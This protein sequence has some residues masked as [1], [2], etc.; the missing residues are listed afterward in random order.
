[1]RKRLFIQVSL[2]IICALWSTSGLA[3]AQTSNA[4][5][6]GTV[7]DPS[8]S[9][10]A[11]ATVKAQ[12]EATGLQRTAVTESSGHYV[13]NFLPVG[14]YVVTAE[15]RGF[16]TARL[17][18]VTLEIGQTRSLDIALEVG[19]VEQTVEI[20]E[21][22]PP[23]D[24]NSATVGTV[25]QSS[26][27]KELPLNGRNWAGLMLLAPGAINTGEGNHLSTRF[28]GRSR[29][30][31]NWTFDGVDST[32]VKDPRQEANLRLVI[33][34]DSIS[35]FRVSSTLY[36]A[37]TGSGAGGQVQVVSRSGAND[38]HGSAYEFLRNNIF[39]ARVFTDPGKLPP[40]RL[41]QFGGRLGGPIAKDKTFFF[42]NYEGIR[43]RQGQTFRGFVP[44]AAYRAQV[45]A[46][47]PALAR[48]VNAYPVGTLRT[49]DANI[50]E[51]VTERKF[52]TR[53]DSFAGRIDHRFSEKDSIYGRYSI[54]DGEL[55]VPQD[56]GIGLRTDNVRPQNFVLNWQRV[57][58][59][60]VVNEAKLGFNRSPL[61]RIDSGPFDEE[62]SVSGFMTLINNQETVEAGT[63]FSFIDNLAVVR[64]RHN[65]KFGGE[66]RRIHVNVG[67][68]DTT[69]IS[70][71]SRPDFINNRP[72]SFAIT[73]FPVLGGRRW[74]YYGYAQDDFKVRPNLTL[75]L[76]VRYEY[77][78][79]A[80][81]VK[82][83]SRVF[84]PACNGFCPPGS[85]WY[86]PDRNNFGPRLGLAWSPKA[87]KDKTVIRAGYGM[88]YGPGQVDD[89]F[90][91]LDSA[92][93]RISLDRTQAPNLSYP[94]APFLALARTVGATPRALQ[95]DRR[96]LYSENYSL[97]IQQNLPWDFTAQIGYVGGQG[98]HLFARSFVNV[99]NPATGQR[100][101]PAFSRIDQKAS[102]GNSNFHGLQVSLHRQ[103][104]S[105]LLIGAQYM[106]SHSINDNSV[107]GGEAAAAQNVNDRRAE[108][109]NSNQDIRHTLTTNFIWELPFG[110]GRRYLKEGVAE[111][112]FGGWSLNGITQARTGRQLT[113][114]VT[115][116]SGDLP[117][118]NNSNQRPDVVLGAPLKPANQTA[119]QWINIAAFAVPPRGRWGTAGRSL[120]TGPGLVQFDLGLT[121]SFPFS[122]GRDIEFRWELYN[123]FNRAQLGDPALNISTPATFGR[124]TA[125]LNRNFGT[126]T[127]RQMQFMLRLNF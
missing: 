22:A 105:G 98:H 78:S 4:T 26:Q 63:S 21:T 86:F 76:G 32:G 57:F 58:S 59:P 2:T 14:R 30:D 95:R 68:G 88:F 52:Q 7:T 42:F 100:P 113:I 74:Y 71:T 82:G 80:H 49:S 117:D 56:A 97:T 20:T 91:A 19:S 85:P 67:E 89:V 41:N 13:F 114:S 99:I 55:R 39:D 84:D 115:R 66:T 126:G 27:I 101:L 107:G 90:A 40:F 87:L 23:L 109:A 28:V 48:I 11:N 94:I 72:N 9:V 37:D 106:W 60:T 12:S 111:W 65:L 54:D 62:F 61:L 110:R 73:P 51:V 36:A 50:D 121:K 3:N 15:A 103:M 125:P 46:T 119:T 79:V 5:L 104:R 69:T 75:N 29:D 83:R 120:L 31:N 64:G 53:E 127:N 44:S 16:K 24:R 122:E 18:N 38:F 116:S 25:I 33:S 43:Q 124:V 17:S 6:Q 108:R 8:G 112:V 77:Y 96:D 70:F 92:A 81:E 93:D 10:V 47:S 123:A 34:T 45:A 35:E 1:M 118:G 102:I